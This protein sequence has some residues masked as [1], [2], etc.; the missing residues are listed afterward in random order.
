[1][2]SA[3]TK[4]LLSLSKSLRKCH[5]LQPEA[6]VWS[7]K[8][9]KSPHSSKN[10]ANLSQRTHSSEG[11]R[12]LV[13]TQAHLTAQKTFTTHVYDG[14]EHWAHVQNTASA[15]AFRAHASVLHMEDKETVH[16]IEKK[17]K[18]RTRRPNPPA[19]KNVFN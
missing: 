2:P 12:L 17:K 11:L 15:R 6:K 1:M 7:M 14:Q 3:A 9:T 10:A 16:I 19:Q 4:T 18:K 13:G 8:A 5:P